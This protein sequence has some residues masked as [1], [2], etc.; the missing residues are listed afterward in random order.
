VKIQELQILG[1]DSHR[2]AGELNGGTTDYGKG[3][4]TGSC[5]IACQAMPVSREQLRAAREPR[6]VMRV[7]VPRNLSSYDLNACAWR[8]ASRGVA[9]GCTVG[10]RETGALAWQAMSHEPVLVPFA[11][12]CC[13]PIEFSGHA[14]SVFGLGS[15]ILD[16]H[17]VRC[18]LSLAVV[19][20][21]FMGATYRLQPRRRNAFRSCR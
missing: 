14:M 10:S 12:V 19:E 7:G 3:T 15:V 11:I 21:V 20:R 5:D 1:R 17:W 8:L 9:P 4:R 18:P 13:S 6:L 16:L 2:M